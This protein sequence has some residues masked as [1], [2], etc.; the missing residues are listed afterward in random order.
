[1]NPTHEIIET[2]LKLNQIPRQ[3]IKWG[4]LLAEAKRVREAY[5]ARNQGLDDILQ[6]MCKLQAEAQ[7][8]KFN[9]SI[10]TLNKYTFKS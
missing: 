4:K 2:Y 10:S 1:M 9:W 8:Y 3:N 5:E 7:S 6:D